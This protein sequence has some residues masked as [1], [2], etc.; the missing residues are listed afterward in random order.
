MARRRIH[1]IVGSN[2]RRVRRSKGLRQVDIVARCQLIGWQ[3]TRE[4]LAKI[5]A[6]LRRVNDAEVAMLARALALDVEDLLFCPRDQ[7]LDIARHGED[8]L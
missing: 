3:L 7:L 6:D 8:E 4:T 5:E 2:L 1:N